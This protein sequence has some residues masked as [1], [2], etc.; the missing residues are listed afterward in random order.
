VS[1]KPAASMSVPELLARVE[2]W[3]GADHWEECGALAECPHGDYYVCTDSPTCY[4]PECEGGEERLCNCYLGVMRG[5]R[6]AL[7]ARE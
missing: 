1:E 2:D 3:D 5:L 4:E 6:D 7:K